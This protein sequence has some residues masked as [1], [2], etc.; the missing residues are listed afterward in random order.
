MPALP[1][2]ALAALGYLALGWNVIPVE[3]GESR[4]PHVRWKPYQAARVTTADVIGWWTRWPDANCGVVTGAISG[5]VVLDVDG[6]EGDANRARF[7][8]LP[9]TPRVR[10]RNGHHYYFRHPGVELPPWANPRD[11]ARTDPALRGLDFRGDGAFIVAPPSVH[12]SGHVYV[13]EVAP[14]GL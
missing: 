8:T 2:I 10:T 5:L 12:H 4:K 13:W 3:R 14:R 1:P 11:S 9:H 7:G 6:A